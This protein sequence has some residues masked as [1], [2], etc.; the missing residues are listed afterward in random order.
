MAHAR[1]E[2]GHS[3][4]ML[5]HGLRPFVVIAAPDDAPQNRLESWLD[6]VRKDERVVQI[7]NPEVL[8][9][10]EGERPHWR[11]DVTQPLYVKK[12]GQRV[13]VDRG[14]MH[15]RGYII[16]NLFDLF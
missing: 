3:V 2:V 16:K 10:E 15:S 11:V 9:C 8:W 14:C 13:R 7:H 1:A 5:I 12:G 4:T 6:D